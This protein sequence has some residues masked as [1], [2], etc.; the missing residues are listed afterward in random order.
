MSRRFPVSLRVVF[1]LLLALQTSLPF[2]SES[3]LPV[4]MA[5]APDR[6][7]LPPVSSATARDA[8]PLRTFAPVRATPAPHGV[9]GE[10]PA[11]GHLTLTFTA[12]PLQVAPDGVLTYTATI[13]NVGDAALTAVVLVNALPTELVYVAGSAVGFDYDPDA[14]QL[15]WSVGTLAWGATL[16][17]RFQASLLGAA[18]G[19]T[20]TNTVRATNADEPDAIQAA[21]AIAVVAPRSNAVWVTPAQGGALYST[22]GRVELQIPPGVVL[23]PTQIVYTPRPDLDHVPPNI[24]APFALAAQDETGQAVREFAAAL[25]LRVA[26]TSLPSSPSVYSEPELFTLDEARGQW[27]AVPAA[28]DQAAGR[29]QATLTHFSIYSEGNTSYVLERAS[30]V[31]GAQT[32]LFTRS[33]GYAYPFELPPG[34]GGLTPQ[35]GLSYSSANHTPNSGHFSYPGFGWELVGADSV[36]TA[37]GDDNMPYPTLSL[38]GATY[39][40]RRTSDET[41]WFAKENPF[42]KIQAADVSHYTP[43]TWYVWTPDGVKYTFSAA[44]AAAYYWKLCNTGDVGKRYVRV[45]LVS[46]QDAYSNTVSFTWQ[47]ETET[48]GTG[49]SDQCNAAT[50]GRALRLTTLSYNGGAVQVTLNYTTREDRPNGFDDTDW[51]FFTEQRLTDVQVQVQENGAGTLRTVR[52]YVLGHNSQNETDMRSQKVLNLDWLEERSAGGSALPRTEFTYTNNFFENDGQFG[53]LSLVRNGYGGEVAFQSQNANSGAHV[54]NTRTERDGIDGTP[55]AVWSYTSSAWDATGDMLNPKLAQGYSQVTVT[56]PTGTAERHDF[57]VLSTVSNGQKVDHLAGRATQQI[58]LLGT[59]ELAKTVTTWVSTTQS[60]PVTDTVSSEELQ[61]RFVYAAASETH[62]DGQR[63]VRT[64]S[65]YQTWRQGASGQQFGNLTEQREY[66]GTPSNWEALPTRT[67]YFWFYP[68]ESAWLIHKLARTDLY[69]SCYGCTGGQIVGQTLFYYDQTA[70]YT[71]TPTLGQLRQ[72][73]DGVGTE[74]L[75]T[76]QY[77]YW[78]NGNLRQIQDG[79]GNATETFYDSAFQSYPVCVKN[80]LGQATVTRYYGVPGSTEAG[81][82]T[83]AGLLPWSGGTPVAG[84]V[85]G[86]VEDTTDA[87]NA[88]TSL[89]YDAWGRV[90]QVWRPGE[91]IT[92]SATLIITYTNYSDPSAPFNVQQGQRDDAVGGSATSTY[93]KSYTFYDGLGQAIQTQAEAVVNN[94]L[95]LTQTRYDGVRQV[96]SQTLPYTVTASLGAYQAPAGSQPQTQTAYDGLGRTTVVTHT[97]GSTLRTYYSGLKTL[98]LDE[99]QHQVR[100]ETDAFGRLISSQQYSGTFSSPDWNAAPYATATYSYTVR[101]QLARVTGADSTSTSMTYDTLGRKTDLSDPNMGAWSYTYDAAGN[102]LTQTDAWDCVTTFAYDELNRLVSKSY[103]GSGA[104]ADTPAVS[105]SYDQ[106]ANGAGR[107]TALAYGSGYGTTWRYDGRGR[108]ISE[109]QIIANVAYTTLS[110]YDAADRLQTLTYPDGEV[111]TTTYTS[112][113]LAGSLVGADVYVQDTD[114]DAAGRVTLRKLGADALRTSYS[115]FAWT[116]A[117]GRGRLQQLQAGPPAQ[118]SQLQDAGYTY[119]AAGN[120]QTIVDA[121]NSDQRQCFRYDPLD[122]LTQA[123]TWQDSS[124]GCSAQAGEGNYSEG[125]AYAASGNLQRKGAADDP[126]DGLYTYG[127]ANHPHAVTHVGGAPRACYDADGNQTVRLVNG[128]LHLLTYDAENRLTT[129]SERSSFSTTLAL[130][131]TDV[132]LTWAAVDSAAGYAVWRATTPYF[133]P[134]ESGSVQITTTTAT[135]YTDPDHSGDPAINYYYLV[136]ATAED[137]PVGVSPRLGEFDFSLVPGSAQSAAATRVAAASALSLPAFPTE[138]LTDVQIAS[139][140]YDGD[141]QRVALTTDGTTTIYIGNYFEWRGSMATS[142]SYYYAGGTRVAL[143]TGT[144]ITGTVFYLVGDHLGSS[145][146]S[147][148]ADGSQ[149]ATQRYY[150]WGSVRA[151]TGGVLPTDYTFTGQKLDASAGLMYCGARY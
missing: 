143:R 142:T 36:Y 119:D 107:R 146:V 67:K 64:E 132:L 50:Y 29:L 22:D 47:T 138:T 141:G 71:I 38:Q 98:T 59:L 109:T 118:P 82:T 58:V 13:A 14:R 116:T 19:A 99:L 21:A 24:L 126:G 144:P 44:S 133:T 11:F 91:A 105:Y 74:Q 129:I 85:F 77:A 102:L 41:T 9:F 123:T 90:T 149:T 65:E 20:V 147:Y 135:S 136:L 130:S 25:T 121:V 75:T 96:V 17:G 112:Q 150:P 127:D 16:S 145:S 10:P 93:L 2:H 7:A 53:A 51:R 18:P 34:R 60:L 117:N 100:Q 151:T 108:P 84:K 80:A 72:R 3:R 62:Q 68:N 128:T 5:A 42:L 134:G 137:C 106:G 114:Y 70:S 139:F 39:S 15:T 23:R 45:P 140:V 125:Y 88:V 76:A 26:Y 83:T 8:P 120:V 122:R 30:S 33:I 37:P 27:L 86:Q 103:S 95:I 113:G 31:R 97:D 81:C 48:T 49:R 12:V 57:V 78:S 35:L 4:V 124:Q 54:V 92:A 79:K 101:D 55:D 56:L 104:C 73:Q 148:R 66:A 87:N 115:Y 32:N 52:S 89:A 6:D 61:P 131:A 111:V 40:L 46:I 69:E 94:Q 110:G 1:V 63:Q 28:V 43:A